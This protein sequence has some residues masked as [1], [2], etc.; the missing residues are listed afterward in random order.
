MP[1]LNVMGQKI[2]PKQ[3]EHASLQKHFAF[4]VETR[5]AVQVGTTRGGETLIPIDAA[6]DDLVE[7]EYSNGL[8][9]W[10]TVEELRTRYADQAADRGLAGPLTITAT[11][12]DSATRG[13]PDLVI[14]GLK[15]LGIDPANAIAERG[16]KAAIDYFESKLTPGPGLYQLTQQGVLGDAVTGELSPSDAPYLLL[17]H[18]TFSSTDGTFHHLFTSREWIDLWHTYD[19]R[20]LGFNHRSLSQSPVDNALALINH[21]PQGAKLHLISHSRGGLVG[22]LLCIDAISAD[23]LSCFDKAE[24][25]SEI[26]T[27]HKLSEQLLAK[28]LDVRRFVR[29]ACPTRGTL[30]ASQRLDRYLS[31][32]L[33]LIGLIPALADS[34]LYDFAKVT[35][36]TLIKKKA[37]PK[38]LP[39]LEAMMPESPLVAMLNRAGRKSSSDLAV[40]AGDLA[41]GGGVWNTLKTW[42]SDVFYRE[43]HDLVVHTKAMYGGL[44]RSPNAVYYFRSAPDMNHFNYFV[45]EESRSQIYGWLTQK[46][47]KPPEEF[48]SLAQVRERA[49]TRAALPIDAPVVILIPGVFA[50]HLK[51][52]SERIWINLENLA[53]GKLTDLAMDRVGV[54]A[55]GIVEDTFSALIDTL[56]NQFQVVV[57]DY[58]WRN[59]LKDEAKPLAEAVEKALQGNR[60]VYLLAHSSGGLL[61]RALM[62]YQRETWDKVC[63]RGG[64]LVMLGTPN[65]GA[66]AMLEMLSGQAELMRMLALLDSKRNLNPIC[67]QFRRYPGL[68]ELLPHGRTDWQ[69]TF[70]A[71]LT[72][73]E[74][75]DLKPLLEDAKTVWENLRD[76]TA[77]AHLC[78]VAGLAPATVGGVEGVGSEGKKKTLRFA[79]STAGDGFVTAALGRLADVPTWI[80]DAAHGDLTNR[81]EYFSALTELLL[82]GTTG[83]I[84]KETMGTVAPDERTPHRAR[85]VLYPN[86]QEFVAAVVGGAIPKLT[87]AATAAT[88][89]LRVWVLHAGLDHASYPLAIGHYDGDTIVGTEAVLDSK[90]DER[91]SQRRQMNLYP[92]KVGTVEMILNPQGQRQ[93]E[94]QGALVIGLGEV[95]Q[96]TPDI[97][98]RGITE[99]ALRLALA[100]LDTRDALPMAAPPDATDPLAKRRASAAFSALLIGTRGAQALSIASAIAATVTGALMANRV[101][102]ERKLID[103]VC[104][105]AV[106]FIEI[107]GDLAIRAAHAVTKVEQYLRISRTPNEKLD[108]ANYLKHGEGGYTGQPTSEYDAGWWLP[109]QIKETIDPKGHHGGE[110]QFLQLTDRARAELTLQAT[111]RTLVERLVEKTIHEST[112]NLDIP[113]TLYELLLPNALKDQPLE[114]TNL[115]LVLD[116]EAAQYPWEMLAE[117][118]VGTVNVVGEPL[119][120]LSVRMGMIRKLEKERFRRHVQ[121][122][123]S[124]NALVIGE[125]LLDDPAYPPLPGAKAEAEAVA[126]VL[127]S[128][129]YEVT[130]LIQSDAVTIINALYAKEYRIIHI[131]GHGIYQPDCPA[132]SGVVLGQDIYL[133]AAEIG[134]LR[135]VPELVFLNCCHL[136]RVDTDPVAKPAGRQPGLHAWN[137]LAASASETLIEI[138]VRA[139]VAAGWAVN[140]R[141][142]RNFAK[143]LYSA[144]LAPEGA[145]QFGDAVRMAR[146]AIYESDRN[147]NTWGA[148]QCYGDPGFVLQGDV[149]QSLASTKIYVAPQEFI[150]DLKNLQSRISRTEGTSEITRFTNELDELEARLSNELP[151]RWRNGEMWSALGDTFAELRDFKAAILRYR[152]ALAASSPNELVAIRTVEQLANLEARYAVQLSLENERKEPPTPSDRREVDELLTNARKRLTLLRKLTPTAERYALFGSYYKRRALVWKDNPKERNKALYCAEQSYSKALEQ[153]KVT[154]KPYHALNQIACRYL[155]DMEF[156]DADRQ[157]TLTNLAAVEEEILQNQEAGLSF[158]D[159]IVRPDAALIRALVKSEIESNEQSLLELYRRELTLGATARQRST[160]LEQ[161]QFVDLILKAKGKFADAAEVLARLRNSLEGW[162]K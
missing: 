28:K 94:V 71:T 116:A 123:R 91:L 82:N 89:T 95:G 125:P 79:D 115:L 70:F 53:M 43:D 2:E 160:V 152:K 137:K 19:G 118:Q 129:Q 51:V 122:T 40:V 106:E 144:M 17:I 55:D 75:E 93:G 97:V 38:D 1:I 18:G 10:M 3:D 151:A 4:T 96:I 136:G 84:K 83:Q 103:R 100:K 143:T 107:Y 77:P 110:L 142:A 74:K 119:R 161:L 61:A 133:T 85:L 90:L 7:L 32:M 154:D 59:S 45:N 109:I 60:K 9:E 20:I 62:A 50:S 64:R 112:T 26:E 146:A 141:A 158:W 87:A 132:H 80:M 121:A 131:A 92:G 54:K 156:T 73:K 65:Y 128:F 39:G 69:D 124:K 24:R 52:A 104:V 14:K 148:Y 11:P 162:L 8:R 34:I 42:V 27:L 114:S 37:E 98:S 113:A 22:E 120:P 81:P 153:Q 33:D 105:D 44:E 25:A 140:D 21:L 159:R 67:Q 117:R 47:G 99:A 57:H 155:R 5:L 150:F 49:K 135:V 48:H 16:V 56:S 63:S 76:A 30:L 134:Q 138:G 88:V 86:W 6:D 139:V 130:S 108:L 72:S 29:V 66:Y 36:L 58:D 101:L 12:L 149:N 78:Y 68:L 157:Q 41:A 31:V 15:L 127:T 102:A 147:T 35:I 145:Q 126:G 13:A 111:Q 46:T 23:D